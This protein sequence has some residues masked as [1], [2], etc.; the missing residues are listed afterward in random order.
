MEEIRRL[1]PKRD[2]YFTID[3]VPGVVP[4]SKPPIRMNKVDLAELK[5]QIQELINKKYI[6]PSVSPWGPPVLFV[7]KKNKTL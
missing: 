2:I 6:R 3:L 4:A 5:S 1:P 7:K